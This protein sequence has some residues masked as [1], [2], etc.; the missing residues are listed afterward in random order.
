MQSIVLPEQ[1]IL[2]AA[3]HKIPPNFHLQGGSS[4]SLQSRKRGMDPGKSEKDIDTDSSQSTDSDTEST[5]KPAMMANSA[6]F[7]GL[8]LP[9]QIQQ[10]NPN[11]T[12]GAGMPFYASMPTAPQ[13]LTSYLP[14]QM[15]APMYLPFQQQQQL[16]NNLRF[17][18][19]Q[20]SSMPAFNMLPGGMLSYGNVHDFSQQQSYLQGLSLNSQAALLHQQLLQQSQGQLLHRSVSDPTT[21]HVAQTS[22]DAPTKVSEETETSGSSQKASVAP[23]NNVGSSVIEVRP[24]VEDKPKR[25]LSAYNLFFKEE[26]AKMIVELSGGAADAL[27]DSSSG[28]GERSRRKK[29]KPHRK[30]GFEELAKS[31]GPKWQSLDPLIKAQYQALADEEKKRYQADMAI[32]VSKQREDMEK[33]RE[34]LEATVSEETMQQY[35]ASSGARTASRKRKDVGGGSL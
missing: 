23:T 1:R 19:M 11:L 9:M 15:Q 35:L 8:P 34:Q 10:P 6:A 28:G 5:A 18:L 14:T 2:T 16:A 17:N 13:G 33:C 31:I 29:Q 26:R 21:H 22:S 25:P 4:H 30:V 12:N 27:S 7:Q 20:S 3:I 32:F 24:K